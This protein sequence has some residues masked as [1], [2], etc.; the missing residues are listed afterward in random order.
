VLVIVNFVIMMTS[1]NREEM[2]LS[3]VP[4]QRSIFVSDAEAFEQDMHVN[5]TAIFA[6]P[7]IDATSYILL[8]EEGDVPIGSDLASRKLQIIA[9]VERRFH[10]LQ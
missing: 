10:L 6:L 1:S 5:W 4:I 7:H 8:K 2:R 9:I 3:S